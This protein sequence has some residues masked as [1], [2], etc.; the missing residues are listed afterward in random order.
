MSESDQGI[1]LKDP[2]EVLYEKKVN[3]PVCNETVTVSSIRSGK[4]RLN[5]TTLNLRPIYNG[6][7]PLLYDVF[8]CPK[9]G[10]SAL[11]RFFTKVTFKQIEALKLMV[12][13]NFK[14]RKYPKVLNY[15]MAIERYKLAIISD[16]VL[17]RNDA[18]QAY[19]CL[20]LLWVYDGYIESLEDIVLIDKLKEQRLVFLKKAYEG[21]FK[22]YNIET[23]PIFGMERS[24]VEYLLGE[25]AYEIGDATES[26]FWLSK[27]LG[28]TQV[29]KRIKDKARDVKELLKT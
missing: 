28:N 22:A 23:F 8:T 12:A 18:H 16:L 13:A 6:F 29:N 24:T 5:S 1:Y 26:R 20:K 10:Y 19:M 3:C 15:P 17:R 27:V 25:L 14:E 11:S 2:E 7:D 9:C 21:F 4:L